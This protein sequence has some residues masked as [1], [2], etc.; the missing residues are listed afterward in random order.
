MYAFKYSFYLSSVK[1]WVQQKCIFYKTKAKQ[2]NKYKTYLI[3]LII[4]KFV[5]IKDSSTIKWYY[6]CIFMS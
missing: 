2:T 5:D 1:M 3:L 6:S 4:N